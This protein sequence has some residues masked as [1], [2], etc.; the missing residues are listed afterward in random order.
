MNI[1]CGLNENRIEAQINT[2]ADDNNMRHVVG[3][4]WYIY[5]LFYQKVHHVHVKRNV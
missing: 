2:L 4:R 3:G 5:H 1:K